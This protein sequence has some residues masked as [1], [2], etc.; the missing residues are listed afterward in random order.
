MEPPQTRYTKSGD[1]HIAYQVV[2]EAGP[3]YV[4]V[5]GFAQN[6]EVI[7]EEPRCARM[8]TRIAS[9]CRLIHF[10][11]RGTGVSDRNVGVPSFEERVEDMTAVMDAEGVERAFVGGFSEGGP[12]SIFFAATHPERTLGLALLGTAAS[13][14]RQDDL[15]W[16]FTPEDWTALYAAWADAWGTGSFSVAAAAPSMVGDDAYLAFAAR[17][18]R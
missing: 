16:N 15:P 10:D 8:L 14:V 2:G 12:M 11:K 3:T 7:W 4:A 13:F 1:V 18:E 9:F 17:Y 6:I 5:P